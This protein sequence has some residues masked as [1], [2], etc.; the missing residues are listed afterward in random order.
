M[1]QSDISKHWLSSRLSND[2]S[3]SIQVLAVHDVYAHN[4]FLSFRRLSISIHQSR[5]FETIYSFETQSIND[6]LDVIEIPLSLQ[7]C[8]AAQR[9]ATCLELVKP[10]GKNKLVN[11]VDYATTYI[12]TQPVIRLCSW[13]ILHS[14]TWRGPFVITAWSML[15][16][17][18]G[19]HWARKRNLYLNQP[20]DKLSPIDAQIPGTH[21]VFP[22]FL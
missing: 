20:R 10:R 15:H 18:K 12:V 19:F 6:R 5:R 4:N 13:L 9:K 16:E 8:A 14:L 7:R 1:W 2:W 11:E 17:K 22:Y 21:N 3:V